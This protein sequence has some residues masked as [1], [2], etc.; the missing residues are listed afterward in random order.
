VEQADEDTHD[1]QCGGQSRK[2]VFNAEITEQKDKAT[3]STERIISKIS[4][5]D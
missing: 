5:I 2:K 3:E 4:R 1:G